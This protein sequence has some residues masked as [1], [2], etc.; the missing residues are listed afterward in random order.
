MGEEFR[1]G[2]PQG[3]FN[4]LDDHARLDIPLFAELKDRIP[5]VDFDPKFSIPAL[6]LPRTTDYIG[7]YPK[8]Q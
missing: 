5:D 4:S 1:R 8:V 3:L 2:Y 7:N 6:G